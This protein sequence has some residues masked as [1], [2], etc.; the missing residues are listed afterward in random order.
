MMPSRRESKRRTAAASDTDLS[1]LAEE[2]EPPPSWLGPMLRQLAE[3]GRC[4]DVELVEKLAG[5]GLG[6]FSMPTLTSNV[7]LPAAIGNR[8]ATS[9]NWYGDIAEDDN[10]T[11]EPD[12]GR[13]PNAKPPSPLRTGVSLSDFVGWRACWENYATLI[14]LDTF[15]HR[16]QLA[17]FRIFLPCSRCS[18]AVWCLLSGCKLLVNLLTISTLASVI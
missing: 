12:R 11:A 16:E 18:V 7:K 15:R 2:A 10:S 8:A 4:L 13:I 14:H 5:C 6:D 3:D 1:D 9:A 17:Q